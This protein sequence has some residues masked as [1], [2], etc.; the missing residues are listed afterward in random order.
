MEFHDVFKNTAEQARGKCFKTVIKKL[1]IL[2][3]RTEI[4]LRLKNC[5]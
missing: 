4:T 2:G 1:L 5:G 3:F